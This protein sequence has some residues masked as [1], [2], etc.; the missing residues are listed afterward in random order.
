VSEP[1]YFTCIFGPA[2]A[3]AVLA[4]KAKRNIVNRAYQAQPDSIVGKMTMA[5]L[6]QGMIEWERAHQA[7]TEDELNAEID[8]LT[9]RM[10]LYP[11]GVRGANEIRQL[12]ASA[13][14]SKSRGM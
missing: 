2:T 7:E 14:P 12:R 8:L 10:C 9:A 11:G 3:R 1:E 4:Y 5:R 6:D 13:R